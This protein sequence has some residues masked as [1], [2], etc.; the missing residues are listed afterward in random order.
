MKSTNYYIKEY[1]V[2]SCYNYFNFYNISHSLSNSAISCVRGLRI[3]EKR[4]KA[5]THARTVA[6]SAH[7]TTTNILLLA[8]C[9]LQLAICNCKPMTSLNVQIIQIVI[10]KL[11]EL[12]MNHVINA[13]ST[14]LLSVYLNL[15]E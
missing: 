8:T 7:K 14:T 10:I 1:F 12:E 4:T 3:E 2:S 5:R 15:N 6:E 13:F 9:N 11:H